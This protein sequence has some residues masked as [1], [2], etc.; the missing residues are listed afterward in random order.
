MPLDEQQTWALLR[1]L[2]QPGHWEVPHDFDGPAERARFERLAERL[3]HR[4][5]CTCEV[6]RNVQDASHLGRIAIPAS[7]TSAGDLVTV[8]VSNFGGLV[9]VTLGNPGS[10]D[11]DE[12]REFFPAPVREQVEDELEALGY[13]PVSEHPLWTK[14]TGISGFDALYPPDRPPSWWDRFFEYL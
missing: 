7:A 14:Y 8:T 13:L 4:F 5:G 9:A 1:E 12:E 11:E 10:Y 3:G 6:D 2:D